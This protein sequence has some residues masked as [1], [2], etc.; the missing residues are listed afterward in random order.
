MVGRKLSTCA[1][2]GS[3][4]VVALIGG[5]RDQAT[6]GL[7]PIPSR[8]YAANL[9][10]QTGDFQTGPVAAPLPVPLKVKVTDAG[11][12]PVR[13][14]SVNWVI[15]GGGGSV[16]PPT[17]LS[18]DAGMVFT[19]WTLGTNLGENKVR[20]YLA[21]SYLLDSATFTAT[22]TNG[23]GV[24]IT[25]VVASRPPATAAVATVLPAIS[26]TVVDAFGHPAPGAVVTFSTGAASGT[27]AP[28]S[29]IA[30]STGKVSTVWTT[31]NTVGVQTLIVTLAGQ[32]PITLSVTTTADTSR[33]LAIV[34][35]ANQTV[36]VGGS[37]AVPLTVRITDQFGNPITG[38]LV[39]FN[40]S[41]GNG[42]SMTPATAATDVT[43]SASSVWKVGAMAGVQ[44]VRVRTAGSGGQVV[45]FAT[46][47]LLTF[48]DVFAGEYFACG[49]TTNDR[50]YCWGFGENGQLG[51]QSAISRNAPTWPVTSVDT[52]A[53]PYPSLRDVSGGADHTCGVSIARGLLCWGFSPDT[54]AFLTASSTFAL[55]AG[56]S[57]GISSVRM[58]VTG[59]S[60][61]CYIS[62]GGNAT[63]SGTNENGELGANPLPLP[64]VAGQT[65]YSFVAAGWRHGCGM[66]RFDPA[67][68]AAT[69]TPVCW[70][71]NENGQLGD[72]LLTFND[73]NGIPPTFVFMPAGVFFDST[74][75]VAG[76]AHTC[77]LQSFGTPAG[78]V[79]YCWGSNAFGQLGNG[80]L[81]AQGS[82]ASIP[83]LVAGGNLFVRLYAG[84]Y[85]TCGLTQAG[86]AFCWGR[87]DFGQLGIGA[88]S[89]GVS[90]PTAAA[91]GLLFRNLAM[92]ELFSCGIT[93]TPG[94][95]GTTGLAGVVFCWGD[96]EYGQ[97]GTG[98]FGQNGVPVSAAQRVAFQQ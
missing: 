94:P 18:D 71:A 30:D 69:R 19:T 17:G 41:I 32:L 15:I 12:N 25:M 47:A 6:T 98:L 76:A 84:A 21:T 10:L 52:I 14:A 46:T 37:L 59:Q 39:V 61:S 74:S 42:G 78:G 97:L 57:P 79:A 11:G 33:R 87:N 54:R 26:F 77:A 56:G 88:A 34:S 3:L 13:G 80:V 28:S 38:D 63:C 86:A 29:A 27:V 90:T 85:S 66:A 43:G 20:A 22:A 70:G 16:N 36:T 50:A 67:Q 64:L 23:D 53:G 82:R 49:V 58:V 1:L 60:F 96:N 81:P 93:G 31:G 24:V 40:D 4:A 8:D 91:G 68:P 35:G 92:G 9:R 55:P 48:R 51:I 7:S 83:Q 45:R 72:G 5:C 89:G 2:A 65:G 62:L 73:V 75:I 95:T 44:R